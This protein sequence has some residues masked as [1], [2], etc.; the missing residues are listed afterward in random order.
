MDGNGVTRREFEDLKTEV[1]DLKKGG[2]TPTAVLQQKV[3][4]QAEQIKALDATVTRLIFAIVGVV[5]LIIGS[6]AVAAASGLT[7]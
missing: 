1:R 3:E 7:G 4:D 6:V 2:S 5:F